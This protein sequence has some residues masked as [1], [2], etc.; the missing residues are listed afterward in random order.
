MEHNE[1][2]IKC[3][4]KKISKP[5]RRQIEMKQRTWKAEWKKDVEKIAQ[6]K[7]PF[8]VRTYDA[9]EDDDYAYI[10]MEYCENG[11]VSYLM[12]QRRTAGQQFAEGVSH[13][14]SLVFPMLMSFVSYFLLLLWYCGFF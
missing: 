10:V 7:S 12:H 13:S 14:R 5:T 4:V 2:R 9:F 11:D 1:K 3:A 8:I 6:L